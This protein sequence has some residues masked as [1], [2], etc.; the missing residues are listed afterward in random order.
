MGDNKVIDYSLSA[1]GKEVCSPRAE[2]VEGVHA[3]TPLA[4]LDAT[5]CWALV[6]LFSEIVAKRATRTRVR[7]SKNRKIEKPQRSR[8]CLFSLVS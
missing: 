6:Q 1:A 2:V 7:K 3:V 4:A 5:V 8:Q